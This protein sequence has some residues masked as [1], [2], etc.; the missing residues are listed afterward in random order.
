MSAQSPARTRFGLAVLA[1]F[2]VAAT[3]NL[4]AIPTHLSWLAL[5]TT[6]LLASSLAVWVIARRGPAL[7]AVALFLSAVGDI[8]LNR[9]SMFIAGMAFFALAHVA[10][11]SHFLRSGALRRLRWY[12][13]AGYAMVWAA[14]V[15]ALW[16]GLGDL[17]VPVTVYSL[18]L[19]ATAVTSSGLTVTTA[20]GGGL[21]FVSDAL[22]A[23]GLADLP[24]PPMP[25]MWVM[26]TYIAAQFLLAWGGG[27]RLPGHTHAPR[28]DQGLMAVK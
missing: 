14:L 27:G 13:V 23:F 24:R 15:V 20:V 8:L 18:L 25:G 17:R 3:G 7:V 9:G 2:V 21:F 5:S 6:C 1:V 11:V 28:T 26:T 4:V 10:Y 16:P 12:L 19:T 22:I